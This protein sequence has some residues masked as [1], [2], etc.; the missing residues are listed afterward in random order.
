MAATSYISITFSHS[1]LEIAVAI[2][3]ILVLCV[4]LR[5]RVVRLRNVRGGLPYP[6]GPTPLPFIGNLFDI[7]RDRESTAYNKMANEY[8]DLTYLNVFGKSILVVNNYATVQ[9]LFDK[10]SANYSDRSQSTMMDLMGWNWN[11]GLMRYG[12][13]WK[14]H[15]AMFHRQFQPS[16]VSA[17]WPTQSKEAHKLLLRILHEPG[18][19]INHLRLNSASV[20][21]NVVYGIELQDQD[22]HY[23]TVAETALDGMA[24]AANPGAFLVDIFPF[25]KYVPSWMPGA[26]FK[27][28]AASWRKSVLQMRDAPFEEVTNI[29]KQ[30]NITSSFV[31]NLLADLE[32]RNDHRSNFILPDEV[33]TIKNCAGLAYAAGTESFVSSLSSFMLAMT[34]WPEVQ[35]KARQEL[36]RVVGLERLPDFSDRGTLPYIDAIVKE[37]LRWNPVAPLGLPHMSTI[38]DEFKGY[39]IPAGTIVLGNTW[40]ILHDPVTYPDPMKFNPER[41]L[42]NEPT[43]ID[44]VSVAFGYG[45]RICPGRFMAEGQLW[46]SIACILSVFDITPGDRERRTE[47]AFGSGLICHPLPFKTSIN[48]RSKQAK[49]L[50]EQTTD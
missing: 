10:R 22:D 6:P 34:L 9:E 32:L 36:D 12:P 3:A 28:Q 47:A 19:L 8:G 29:M 1:Q 27:R 21:M 17:F 48:V 11:F 23:I 30:E 24:K 20:I 7:P 39:Y 2:L 43:I 45:R 35:E 14:R 18:D 50:I 42:S 41:F 25:F 16:G 49:S 15:R 13:D 38:D 46:I 5:R 44:P 40:T 26:G 33:E 4:Y 37:V 31:S